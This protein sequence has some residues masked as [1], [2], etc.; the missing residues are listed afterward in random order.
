MWDEI[1]P[2]RGENEMKLNEENLEKLTIPVWVMW[3][4]GDHFRSGFNI[5]MFRSRSRSEFFWV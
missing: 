1:E 4:F 3:T 5:S 2:M